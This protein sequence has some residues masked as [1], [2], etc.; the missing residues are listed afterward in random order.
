MSVKRNE[1][2]EGE[3]RGKGG[4]MRKKWGKKKTRWRRLTAVMLS[5]HKTNGSENIYRE[6]ESEYSF[7]S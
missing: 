4:R 7:Q 1:D 5:M 6:S 2:V 3:R